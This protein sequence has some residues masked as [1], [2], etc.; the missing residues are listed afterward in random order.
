LAISILFIS[1]LCGVYIFVSHSPR[2]N[3]ARIYIQGNH[4]VSEK[5]IFEKVKIR[6]GT[7]IFRM[8]LGIIENL[9]REDKRIK[10]VRVK[11][12]LPNQVLIEVEE[13]KSALWINLPEGLFGLSQDQ[14]IIP[15]EEEDF[16][17]DLPVV[18]GL[19]SP[20]DFG[21]QNLKA[22][23]YEWWP[24][25][26]AKWAL[27]FYKILSEQ[28][29]SFMELISEISLSDESNLVFYLIP[30]GTQVNMGNG[31]FKKKLKRVKAFLYY[32]GKTEDLACLDLR[33]KDQVVVKK[34]S[35]G[36]TESS[37]CGPQSQMPQTKQ[38]DLGRKGNL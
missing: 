38:K 1:T 20:S 17:H 33:F 11:R 35:T 28:D 26:K 31:N 19:T 37:S 30:Y 18:T 16:D 13:K 15:L 8:D 7:N 12:V 4:K 10:E 5:E 25:R 24:N 32:E 34:S 9:V 6:L 27:D 21:K 29:S 22:K 36:L 14:E 23:P 2:F 3:L